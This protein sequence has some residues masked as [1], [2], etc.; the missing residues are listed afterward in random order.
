MERVMK[1]EEA[2]DV[3]KDVMFSIQVSLPF[4]KRGTTC[5]CKLGRNIKYR[6]E[7]TVLQRSS[8][9]NRVVK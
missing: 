1:T 6:S 7:Y 2:R 3:C 5:K 9:T 4:Q 8:L